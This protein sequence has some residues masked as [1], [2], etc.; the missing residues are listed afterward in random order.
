M[1]LHKVQIG[2]KNNVNVQ[3]LPSISHRYFSTS[4]L[5]EIKEI[6][7]KE[8]NY[9]KSLENQRIFFDNLLVSLNLNSLEDLK[10]LSYKTIVNNGG[11]SVLSLYPSISS[12]LQTIYP[13]V[14]WK[15]TERGFYMKYPHQKR[16]FF[17]KLAI[18]LNIKDPSEWNNV[19][20]RT[21]QLEGGEK[22]LKLY[23]GSVYKTIKALYPEHDWNMKMR[24]RVIARY[25]DDLSNQRT[26]LNEFEKKLK[27][28]SLDDWYS[29]SHCQFRENNGEVL[30]KK[31]KGNIVKLLQTNYP[32]YNW[33]I[34]RLAKKQLRYWYNIDIQRSYFDQ[35]IS[36]LNF[37]NLDELYSLDYDHFK[38]FGA[39]Q[40][41]FF[42]SKNFYLMFKN[43]YPNY[44][45]EILKFQ[46][47][48]HKS[49]SSLLSKIASFE[50]IF[51][52]KKNKNKTN[53]NNKDNNI[54]NY[55][56]NKDSNDNSEDLVVNDKNINRSNIEKLKETLKYELI[57][58]REALIALKKIFFIRKMKDW[59]RIPNIMEPLP[60]FLSLSNFRY[61]TAYLPSILRSHSP[62]IKWNFS[63]YTRSKK[64]KQ[65]FLFTTLNQLYPN[66]ILLEEYIHPLL[67]FKSSTPVSFDVYIPSLN[68]G[69]E[70]QGEQHYDEFQGCFAPF[71]ITR[72]LDQQKLYHSCLHG[73]KL[74]CVPYWWD[75]SPASLFYT[76]SQS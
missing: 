45:F 76:L 9:F 21:I 68:M 4:H 54:D 28:K 41:Y 25:W 51:R 74:V 39:K 61:M 10:T 69:I 63:I 66:H 35:F 52:K 59:Y 44:P 53:N 19:T 75:L 20:Y 37:Y 15:C 7:K 55:N 42:Y 49:I 73:I 23:K 12:A 6:K 5:N 1:G 56:D 72:D 31:Y 70:Y 33:D 18:K 62:E 24:P 71:E 50:Q 46:Q 58:Q 40:I 16:L 64:S 65:F 8:R 27:F 34:G 17:D 14:E 32:N 67:Q 60:S 47:P 11:K 2:V 26:F 30:L 13:N 3:L 29:I 57:F 22:I 38:H 36:D 48:R 43:I